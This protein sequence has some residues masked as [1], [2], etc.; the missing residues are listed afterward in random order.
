MSG[1][2]GSRSALGC[3]VAL[4]CGERAGD[5]IVLLDANADADGGSADSG[6]GGTG[7]TGQGA[8]TARGGGSAGAGSVSGGSA[9]PLGVGPTG[10]CG[11]CQASDECGDANDA[12]IRHDD[13]RFCGRDCYDE[14]DCPDGY[15]CV[16]LSNSQLHQCVPIEGCPENAEVP[17]SLVDLRSYLL[18]RIN[19][20]RSKVQ[21]PPLGASS[22]LD[23]LAQESALSFASTDEP[24]GKYVKECDPIWPSCACGWNAEA[25]IAIARYGLDW[26]SATELALGAN[27]DTQSDRFVNAFLEYD[28]TDV[29]IG[30]W[31]SGDEAWIA[32]SFR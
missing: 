27:R 21:Q 14:R 25:E 28:A 22:C 19:D 16:E 18:S 32:L 1:W 13:Q 12:C 31:I 10:L 5:P 29:G 7:G 30:F 9:A 20:E 17:P 3:V 26:L 11:A 6:M 15:A 2:R 24:L 23:E 8:D 4:A